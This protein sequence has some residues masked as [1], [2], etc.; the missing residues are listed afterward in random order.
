MQNP[1]QPKNAYGIT[2]PIIISVGS[3]GVESK[4]SIEPSSYSLQMVSEVSKIQTIATITAVSP[5]IAN[6]FEFN[7][8]LNN[9]RVFKNTFCIGV[10]VIFSDAIVLIL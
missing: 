4:S 9:K 5:G 10:F 3:T 2:F 1:A 6:H 8:G 7:S